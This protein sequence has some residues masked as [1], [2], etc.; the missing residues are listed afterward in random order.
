MKSS[1]FSP[2]WTD[3]WKLQREWN[4]LSLNY[5]QNRFFSSLK[6]QL[7]WFECMRASAWVKWSVVGVVCRYMVVIVSHNFE[8]IFLLIA[9]HAC[10]GAL[11]VFLPVSQSMRRETNKT[12]N[13]IALDPC[14]I[15]SVQ[16]CI[17]MRTDELSFVYS[18]GVFGRI[19]SHSETRFEINR[20]SVFPQNGNS[21]FISWNISEVDD[22]SSEA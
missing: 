17:R 18:Y 15:D 19:G 10:I 16:R 13:R 12:L 8:C 5:E 1:S 11:C 21:I 14:T 9:A 4:S 6:I 22:F 2:E 3:E 7:H 20:T